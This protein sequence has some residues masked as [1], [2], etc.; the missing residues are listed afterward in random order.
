MFTVAELKA[1]PVHLVAY[2]LAKARAALSV[3]HS[4]QIYKYLEDCAKPRKGILDIKAVITCHA[5]ADENLS[6]SNMSIAR[7]VD[8][9]WTGLG[10]QRTLCRYKS[11][12]SEVPV[13]ISN[14]VTIAGRLDNGTTVVDVVLNQRRMRRL[15]AE[16][17][18]LV[19]QARK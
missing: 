4:R 9:N 11:L 16:V 17:L 15:E 1:T 6:V 18:K 2:K 13:L 12:I 3:A 10:G 8:I 14:T 7:V 5:D 19:D